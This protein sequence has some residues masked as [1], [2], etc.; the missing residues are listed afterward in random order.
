MRAICLTFMGEVGSPWNY[1]CVVP[2]GAK[3]YITVYGYRGLTG[4]N[5]RDM[6]DVLQRHKVKEEL[7]DSGFGF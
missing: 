3:P 1:E 6:R 7:P 2:M 4:K 5:V